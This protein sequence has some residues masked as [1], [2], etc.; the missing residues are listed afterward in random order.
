MWMLGT[1]TGSSGRAAV[2]LT[3]ELFLQA[4]DFVTLQHG[5]GFLGPWNFSINFWNQFASFC[6]EKASRDLIDFVL[7]QWLS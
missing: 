2:L 5:F 3:T 1:E 6:K 7:N 4:L